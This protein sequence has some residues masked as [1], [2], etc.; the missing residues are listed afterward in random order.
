MVHI[1]KSGATLCRHSGSKDIR[2]IREWSRFLVPVKTLFQVPQ[3]HSNSSL[4]AW[5]ARGR[6]VSSYDFESTDRDSYGRTWESVVCVASLV[7]CLHVM[8]ERSQGRQSCHWSLLFQLAIWCRCNCSH[9][10]KPENFSSSLYTALD[11]PLAC[12]SDVIL[13]CWFVLFSASTLYDCTC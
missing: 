4:T 9:Y 7:G 8:S 1:C 12:L 3:S 6:H 13:S 5:T 2:K 10:K 11:S